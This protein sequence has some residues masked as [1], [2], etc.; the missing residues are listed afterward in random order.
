MAD[1]GQE[2]TG[3]L[4]QVMVVGRRSFLRTI[5][6]PAV[7]VPSTVAP[8]VLLAVFNVGIRHAA[9]L[10]G[11]PARSYLDFIIASTF[12][13]G[14]MF[15]GLGS[16]NAMA[17]DIE[18]GFMN[19]MSLTAVW[20]GP[21]LLGH[22]SGSLVLATIQSVLFLVAALIFGVHVAA[23]V[24]GALVIV[25]LS[26]L[27]SF[28]FSSVFVF[29]AL[30]TGSTE[31]VQGVFPICFILLMF[32]TFFLPRNLMTIRW[33]RVETR[34]NPISYL[35]DGIRSLFITGWDASALLSCVAIA[36]VVIAVAVF[37]ASSSIRTRLLR[38]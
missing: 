6:Q 1:D 26:L 34:I 2:R 33:F 15:L 14:A 9:E 30:R 32:S 28:A 19:R 3:S 4:S 11:F 31:A 17:Y 29:I 27:V 35:I 22:L 5:R 16:G 24:G 12:V 23:G 13:Q 36:V 25:L 38:R 8:L 37:G 21:L 7:F 10:P 20:R 18:S